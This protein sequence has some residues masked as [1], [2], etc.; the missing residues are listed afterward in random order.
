MA[1][2]YQFN[3]TSLTALG[4]QLKVRQKALPTLKNKESALRME[5]KRAKQ[6]SNELLE[7]LDRSL[8]SYRNMAAL[9]NEFTPGLITV[10]DVMLD[11]VKIAG[12]KTPALREVIFEVKPYSL[13]SEP[14]WYAQGVGILK[15]LAQ[16]GIESEIYLEK[17]NLLDFARKKTTQKVNLYEKVQIPGYQEAIRKIKRFMEDEETLSKASQKIVKTRHQDEEE[18]L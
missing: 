17:K 10:K 1:I 7:E 13:F 14:Q 16:I 3:K 12:I 15:D 4:K 2:K 18:H 6:R 9:W 11:T 5:V 8:S